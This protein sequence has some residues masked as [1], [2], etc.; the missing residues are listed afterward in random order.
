MILFLSLNLIFWLIFVYF[1]EWG[2]IM[3]SKKIIEENTMA[4]KENPKVMRRMTIISFLEKI[5]DWVSKFL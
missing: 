4:I 2:M 1:Y 3:A 5:F